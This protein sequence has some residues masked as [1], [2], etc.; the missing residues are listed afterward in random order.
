MSSVVSVAALPVLGRLLEGVRKEKSLI[1]GLLIISL[2]FF[3]LNYATELFTI[4]ILTGVFMVGRNMCLNLSRSFLSGHVSN[5]RMATG[6][7]MVD[8]IHFGGAMIGPFVAGML[9][10]FVSFS[11]VF[12][13]VSV[14]ALAGAAVIA[15]STIRG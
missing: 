12:T 4:S 1:L 8:M 9:I 11:A 6:M 14:A 3:L 15:I 5:E 7:S 13:F 2:S 10:D